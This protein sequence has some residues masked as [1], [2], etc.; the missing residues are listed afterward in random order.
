[1]PQNILQMRLGDFRLTIKEQPSGRVFLNIQYQKK[2]F[3]YANGKVIGE[4]IFPN[5]S[6]QDRRLEEAEYLRSAFVQ[7]IRAGWTPFQT[8]NEIPK[9]RTSLLHALNEGF[10][11]KSQCALSICH[12]KDLERCIRFWNSFLKSQRK[13]SVTI[14]QL[15]IPL[16]QEYLQFSSTKVSMHRSLLRNTKALLRQPLR[17]QGVVLLWE[18]IQL[19]KPVS[20]L[21]KPIKDVQAL[22]SEVEAFN[23][24]LHLCCLLAY[25][26]LLRPHREIRELTWNDFADDL[27]FISLSGSRNKGKR[28]RIVPIP[29]FV[30]PYLKPSHPSHNIF[31]GTENAFNPDYFKTL[32]G[33]FKKKSV[34]L[35]R[36]QTLYSFR[37]TGAINVFK[38]TGS[39]QK[40][41]S[42]MGHSNLQVTL[43]YLRGLEVPQL[44]VDDMPEL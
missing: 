7:A 39:L 24:H 19:P 28:N 10:S 15:T 38:K 31:T 17:Q 43:T 1:M 35:Q 20:T 14:H 22:L 13:K 34:L 5:K 8:E 12:L 4:D 2:R 32:W 23:P 6:S 37:H 27:S 3:R 33:Y 40:L 21:H 29:A 11:K 9:K 44:S 36:E 42:V 18:E 41:Q 25:G 16:I 26:C 30:L